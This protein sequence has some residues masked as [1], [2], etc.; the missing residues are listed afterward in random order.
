MKTN[1]NQKTV[2]YLLAA[3]ALFSGHVMAQD[4]SQDDD[5]DYSRVIEVTNVSV[6]PDE[7]TTQ[8]KSFRK[9]VYGKI[10]NLSE[11]YR[12]QRSYSVSDVAIV[13]VLNMSKKRTFEKYDGTTVNI[14]DVVKAC[15]GDTSA[16]QEKIR[17]M[18]QADKTLAKNMLYA[19]GDTYATVT[20]I[21]RNTTQWIQ[22]DFSSEEKHV[23]Y[24]ALTKPSALDNVVPDATNITQLYY[25]QDNIAFMA[26]DKNGA[27]HASM[28][29]GNA[30]INPGSRIFDKCLSEI[31]QGNGDKPLRSYYGPNTTERI[32][33]QCLQGIAEKENL[34]AV[35]VEEFTYNDVVKAIALKTVISNSIGFVVPYSSLSE[36]DV[37]ANKKADSGYIDT[38][39]QN[40]KMITQ[41]DSV[42]NQYYNFVPEVTEANS[43]IYRS[44]TGIVNQEAL[45]KTKA[46]TES[47]NQKK[48]RRQDRQ[49]KIK[50]ELR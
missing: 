42:G 50:A 35:N 26:S 36:N 2:A 38:L 20:S 6:T 9:E 45:E 48:W 8:Q 46:L 19:Y 29:V 39:V 15:D 28:M 16:A 25:N 23:L 37:N 22:T 4:N 12:K 10:D 44:A 7:P 30:A 13:D 17:A 31:A 27:F 5:F 18:V 3:S 40:K 43:D 34:Q 41:G 11:L 21:G 47:N 1:F 24:N 33:H 32:V 14:D 49:Q